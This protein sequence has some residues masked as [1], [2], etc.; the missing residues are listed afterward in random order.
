MPQTLYTVKS[1]AP[2]AK[3]KAQASHHNAG[4]NSADL[5]E[6]KLTTNDLRVAKSCVDGN[7]NPTG[8]FDGRGVMVY[9]NLSKINT[10]LLKLARK[11]ALDVYT[12]GRGLRSF[13]PPKGPAKPG[14]VTWQ[15]KKA[16]RA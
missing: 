14:K 3:P 13:T 1:A 5:T 2:K 11:T 16:V 6:Y 4:F 10:K 12:A 7:K 9:S 8:V 15:R